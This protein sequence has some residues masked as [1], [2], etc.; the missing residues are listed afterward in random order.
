MEKKIELARSLQK[1]ETTIGL[2]I[3]SCSHT[4]RGPLKS[5][6][7]LVSLLHNADGYS[8]NE[9]NQLLDL[10]QATAIKL[11]TTLD[12]LEQLL[13]NSKLSLLYRPVDFDSAIKDVLNFFNKDISEKKISVETQLSITSPFCTDLRRVRIILTNLFINAIQFQAEEQANKSIHISIHTSPTICKIAISDN[14]VGIDVENHEKIFNLFFR[15]SEKSKGHGVGLYL[16]RDLLRKMGGT[17]QV[18]S[19]PGSG[20]V[21]TVLI[22]NNQIS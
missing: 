9:T 10:I 16:V 5:I 15:G 6:E 20:S 19:F 2:F 13:E 22:P 14:G 17:I 7:G 3:N 11:E 1:A 18:D 12:E 4:M 21:F 8:K